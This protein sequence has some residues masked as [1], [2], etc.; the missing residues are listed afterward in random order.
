MSRSFCHSWPAAPDLTQGSCLKIGGWVEVKF[1]LLGRS[2]LHQYCRGALVLMLFSGHRGLLA[3]ALAS[4]TSLPA[5]QLG[6]NSHM[7]ISDHYQPPGLLHHLPSS[8]ASH[9]K[10]FSSSFAL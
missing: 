3:G 9:P 1:G 7:V 10:G 8:Q 5:P 4:S 6:G 2:K